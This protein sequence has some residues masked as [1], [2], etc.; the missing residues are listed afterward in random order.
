MN[1]AYLLKLPLTNVGIF[2]FIKFC[3]TN[4]IS[5]YLS[6]QEEDMFDDILFIAVVAPIESQSIL[7][8]KYSNQIKAVSSI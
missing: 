6:W 8:G 5:V 3:E 1:K 2:N 7:E 4:K